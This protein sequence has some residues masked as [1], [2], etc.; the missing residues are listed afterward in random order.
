MSDTTTTTGNPSTIQSEQAGTET[1]MNLMDSVG[2]SR[3]AKKNVYSLLVT[4]REAA[5]NNNDVSSMF[6]LANQSASET[7]QERFK[8]VFG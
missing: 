8:R 7:L 6:V 2:Q 4:A 3:K 5:K 1:F